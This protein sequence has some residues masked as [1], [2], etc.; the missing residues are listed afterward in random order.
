MDSSIKSD[1]SELTLTER[2]ELLRLAR[3]RGLS[4]AGAGATA[5]QPVP[6]DRRA[7][8]SFS[9]QRLWFLERMGDAGEAYFVRNRVR[10]HGH[11]DQN[12]LLRALDEIVARHESLRTTFVEWG[13]EVEQ[14]IGPP[15]SGCAMVVHDLTA[16]DD[17]ELELDSLLLEESTESFD[18]EEGPLFRGRLIKLAQDDHVLLLTM[19][20]IVSD[21]WS[22]GVL[23]REMEELYSASVEGRPA[24]LAELPIQY[25]DYAVWQGRRVGSGEHREQLEYWG[26]KLSGAPALLELPHGRPRPGEIDHSGDRVRIELDEEL[27]ADLKALS[28]ENGMTL[29]MTLLTGWVMLLGRLSARD[30]IVVG[31]P[32][33]NRS[34]SEVEGLI[35]FFVNLVSLRFDL[36]EGDTVAELLE[37]VREGVV[38]SQRHQDVP[39]EQVVD[40]LQPRRSLAYHPIFQVMF[41]WQGASGRGISLPGISVEGVEAPFARPAKTDIAL[42]LGERE[43]RITGSLTYATALFDAETVERYAGYLVRVFRAMVT[44][45]VGRLDMASVVEAEERE[46]LVKHWGRSAVD[47]IDESP[48]H[49]LFASQASETPDAVAA[50]FGESHAT[51]GELDRRSNRLAARLR[52]FGVGPDTLVALCVE[53]SLD[54]LVGLLGVL[55]AGGAYVP[56]DPRHPKDRIELVLADSEPAVVLTQSEFSVLFAGVRAPTLVFEDLKSP[57][58]GTGSGSTPANGRRRVRPENLTYVMYTSGST[59]RPK[60]VMNHHRAVSSMLRSGQEMWALDERDV[61]LQNIPYSFDASV[62]LFS[63]LIAGSRLVLADVGAESDADNLLSTMLRERV[64]TAQFT[65]SMLQVVVDD[66]RL[67][68]CRSLRRVLAGGERLSAT[69]VERFEQ[70][71]PDSELYHM[72][73]PTEATVAVTGGRCS[74][75]GDRGAVSI[76]RPV[77]NARVYV[78][79]AWGE[80]VPTGVAGELFIGGPQVSRGYKGRGDLTAARFVPDPFEGRPG[81]R[82]YRTGD[83]VRWRPDGELEFM[84]RADQQVKVRGFRI[85]PGEIESALRRME[86]IDDAIVLAHESDP[87]RTGHTQL[88]AYVTGAR[89]PEPGVLR[90][91]LADVLPD[92]MVP[93]AY[94]RLSEFPL[95]TTG[96]VDR[97]ALNAPGSDAFSLGSFEPPRGDR[98]AAVAEIWKEVLGVERVGRNDDF[99]ALGGHSLLAIQVLSRLRRRL[100]I[101]I[102]LRHVFARPVLADFA[103]DVGGAAAV[104]LPVIEPARGDE[105]PPLSFAQRRLWFLEQLGD[106]GDAYHIHGRLRLRGSLDE[107]AL[108]AALDEVVARHEALRTTFVQVGDT[109]VQRIAPSDVGFQLE[110]VDLTGQPDRK[111][112]FAEIVV[113]EGSEHFDL[114]VGPLIRGRL[115]RMEEEEHL[116]FV[117]MHHIV[118]DGWSMGVLT[119]ELSLLYNAFRAGVPSPLGPLPIQYG[120]YAAWQRDWVEGEVL[121]RQAEFWAKSLAGAPELLEL[122]LDR[123]RPDEQNHSGAQHA[124]GLDAALTRELDLVA[125]RHGTTVFVVLLS[126]WATLLSRLSG[127]DEVVVGI[128]VANRNRNE[129]EGLIGFFVNTLAVRVDLTGSPTFSEVVRRTAHLVVEA[130]HNQDIP[131]EQVVEV[132]DPTRTLAHQPIFQTMF[133]WQNEPRGE[134]LSLDGLDVEAVESGRAGAAKVDLALSLSE[135]DGTVRGAVTFATAL[136]EPE[137]VARIGGYLVSLLRSVADEQDDAVL[138]IGLMDDGERNQVVRTFNRTAAPFPRDRCAHQLFE[139]R[140]L[141]RPDAIALVCGRRT[142]SY[143][144]LNRRAN[145]LAHHLRRLGVGPDVRVGIYAEKG[146]DVVVAVLAV[147]KA[148]GAH[149]PMD[150][151]YPTDRLRY[152]LS[153]SAPAVV[154][155]QT[156]LLDRLADADI[157]TLVL[158]SENPEWMDCPSSD[159]ELPL[160]DP[161]HLA[162]VIYTSG[163]TGAPKGVMLTHRGLVNLT[164]ADLPEF[165]VD[166]RSRVLQFSSFSFDAFVFETSMA[167]F[168]GA[169]LV[170]PEESRLLGDDLGTLV[171][172]ERITHSVLPASVLSAMPD[173]T[174]LS[175][176]EALISTGEAPASA[177]VDRWRR[178]RTLVNGYG[179]TESSI[180]ATL[181]AYGDGVPDYTCIGG[182][183]PNTQIYVL[184]RQG[185]PVPMGVV[186]ELCIGGESVARGYLGRPDLTAEQFVADPFASEGGSRLYRTGDLARW[187]PDGTLRFVGRAD[188][189]VKLRGFR[190]EL[191]EIETRLL[192]HAEVREAV[193]LAREDEPG[194]RRLVAYL[195]TKGAPTADDLREHLEESLPQYMVP[196]AYVRLDSLPLSPNGKLDR[197]ALPAPDAAAFAQRRYEAPVGDVER[198]LADIWSGLLS[199]PQV[200]RGDNFFELGGHSLLAVRVITQLRDRGL[201]AEVRSLFTA[202]TLAALAEE[203]GTQSTEISVPPNR[204]P[205]GADV[206]TPEMIPLVSLEREELDRIVASVPGG[207]AN[208]EDIYPLAPLQEG[209]FF[210]HLMTDE[211]DPYLLAMTSTFDDRTQLDR[212]LDAQ[213]A[214]IDRHAIMRTAVIWEGVKEPVQVVWRRAPIQVEE[215]ELDPANGD[216][217]DQLY[218]RFSP[219]RYRIDLR[220]AP[221]MKCVV[222]EDRTS[223]RWVLLFL[224]HHLTGDHTT[225]EVLR[226][227][228]AAHLD[229]GESE[230]A[231][232]LPFRNYVAQARLGTSEEEHSEFFTELLGD[233]RES[234]APYGLLD[235]QGDGSGIEEFR[236]TL[237]EDLST[238]LREHARRLGV[239]AASIFHLAWALVVARASARDEVVFGTVLFGRMHGGEGSDRVVGPFINTLPI[240][241]DV[242]TD[243]VEDSV[244]STHDLVARLLRHEHASLALAQRCSGVEAPAPLFTT[245]LN[246]RHSG[247]TGARAPQP[248]NGGAAGRGRG[249]ERTNYPLTMTVDDRGHGFSLKAKAKAQ[250]EASRVAA[251][252]MQA[253]TGL[254]DALEE[255]PQAPVT[256]ID[257]LPAEERH[258]VLFAW[259]AS[260][261][262]YPRDLCVHQLFEGHAERTPE[263]VALCHGTTCLTYGEL[264]REANRLA[265]HLRRRGIGPDVRVGICMDRSLE[266]VIS[267]LAVLKAGGAYVPLDPNYPPDRLRYMVEDSDP[268]VLLSQA[269]LLDR[270]RDLDVEVVAVDRDTQVWADESQDNPARG[271]LTPGHLTHLVYTSGSTGRPKGVMMEHE[272]GVNRFLWMQRLHQLGVDD[273]GAMLQNSSFSF[274][275]SVWELLWPLSSGARVVL[276]PAEA[277]HDLDGLA[278]AIH[279]GDVRAAFFV[280][281]MLQIFLESGGVARSG[282][283]RIMCGGEALPPEL[284]RRL[285][286]EVP[287]IELFNMFGPSEASQAIVGPVPPVQDGDASVPLGRPVPNTRVYVLDGT[288]EPAPVGVAGELYI[289]GIQMARG[290]RSQPALTAER[291][292]PDPFSGR[293]GARLYRTGDLGRWRPDGTIDFL[294]R[295]D[296]QVKVRGFR[297][298]LGEIEARLLEHADV[299]EAVV[300]AREDVPGERRLVAYFVGGD[301]AAPDGL[302]AHL[303]EVL[304]PYMV[305]AAYVRLDELPLTPNGKLDR[306][307]LA[308]PQGDAYMRRGD[309]AP[310]GEVETAVAEIWSEV[311]RQERIGRWDD[312]FEL[313]GHSLLVVQV[314][315]RVRHAL[316][317]EVPLGEL[318]ARPVLEDFARAVREAGHSE[319]P[320]VTPVPRGDRIPLSLAQQRLWFL[321]QLGGVGSTYH[322]RKRR[323]LQGTLDRPAFVKALDAIVARH[324]ALRTSFAQ[325]D[326]VPEQRIAPRESASFLLIEHD[327]SDCEDAREQLA[328]LAHEEVETPFDLEKGPLVRGR[329]V[330]LAED[331]HVFLMTMHH[332]VG[333]A[334][335]SRVFFEEL[336]ALYAGFCEGTE[337]RLPELDV[338][339]PDYAVWQRAHMDGEGLRRQAEYWTRTLS[340]APELLALPADRPRPPR[341]NHV[342]AILGVELSRELTS[343]LKAL[344]R[345]RG[346][347]LY[348]TV[349]AGWAVVLHRLSGQ[350]EVVVGSPTANRGRKEI[351]GLI[352]FF[353][354]T[355]ALRLDLSETPSVGELLERVKERT[356]E[357]QHH[358]DIPFEQ[359]VELVDPTRSLAYSPLYQVVF[360][361]QNTPRGDDAPLPDVELT[362]VSPGSGTVPAFSDLGLE[363]S[364][365]NG[366]IRGV[367]TYATALFDESTVQRFVGYLERVLEG[368]VEDVNRTVDKLP[369][370][371]ETERLDAVEEWHRAP[372][373]SSDE[374]CIHSLFEEHVDRSPDAIAL[375]FGGEA[376]TYQ[377]V[378]QRANALARRLRELGVGPE[379]RVAVCVERSPEMVVALLGVLKAGGAYVPLDPGYPVERLEYMVNDSVPGVMLAQRALQADLPETDVTIVW[380]DDV[381]VGPA[382]RET[383]DRVVDPDD[384]AYVIYTSGSTGRPKGVQVPHR[385]VC[386]V[387]MMQQADFEVGP[388][389]RV[390]QFASL[391]F[392]AAT[393]EMVMALASGATICLGSREELRPGP[394]L[395]ALIRRE[396][397]TI[398]TLPPSALAALPFEAFPALHTITVAGEALP[399]ELVEKWAGQYRLLNL[400]GPTEGSIWSTMSECASDG[401]KPDIG[402]PIGNVRAYVLDPA[403]EP[404]PVGV[405]GELCVGGLGVARGYLGRPDLTADRFLADP[406][407]TG[408]GARMYRTGDLVRRLPDGSLDFLSRLDH[409]IKL[410][411]YRIELGEIAS[412]LREHDGVA[413]AVVVARQDAQ[414]APLLVGYWRGS[415]DLDADALRSHLTDSLPEYMVPAALVSVDAWPLTPNGKLD[416]KALPEPGDDA[417]GAAAFE[418]PHG[419]IEAALAEIWKE[420][421]GRERIGRQDNFF[422]LGG[423]SLLAVQVIALMRDLD[424]HVEVQA[425]F[426]APTLAALAAAAV[427]DT[428]DVE[429]PANRIPDPEVMPSSE[430]DVYL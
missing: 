406:F 67:A 117:D 56:L 113:R 318:F 147:L 373:S 12:A 212:Y 413:D 26:H 110:V 31:T 343:S 277:H 351:E 216:V 231:E 98:E 14:R 225:L 71:V 391:S 281:S 6:R 187:N 339:Y 118:S 3:E 294:G 150:P 29:F 340:G 310:V 295:R 309:E 248:S 392:D 105:A 428:G 342:G 357:A 262:E 115:L 99:F 341:M 207:A 82:L 170:V 245:L 198:A 360:T 188:F 307:A 193:V 94:V 250:V 282:L 132:L 399:V 165:S 311:L 335:S 7:P 405:A 202:P 358:Q 10:L 213:Q 384:L 43:G 163:S 273:P 427:G 320:P 336:S 363:L 92:Y 116:L 169:V 5:I 9:Q 24:A 171:D 130:Q 122:P 400:Y 337:P 194:D 359:V 234:T 333:D 429:V 131:F 75:N 123:G 66:G 222:T 40:H 141:A 201:H 18:L 61:V 161:G 254:V 263:A 395:A 2:R 121:Q 251:L 38:E 275:A 90:A 93:A 30:D 199:I 285:R 186:G 50:V 178:S 22:S 410:R 296:H 284:V 135:R 45:P 261:A 146:A 264:N 42:E 182:P 268:G 87:A 218:E 321:E 20:H 270:V 347:T 352:G 394:D 243:G 180:T 289:G 306:S 365:Q 236:L 389:D 383:R 64:T 159:V 69:V 100:G 185:Q 183:I 300:L 34:R 370:Q 292:V 246:Y 283:R 35:G 423:H 338:Q 305:P 279:G 228:I 426:E 390:L 401:R 409:Q 97:G 133:A 160:I 1:A 303:T 297:I 81:A 44:D 91:R 345:Q 242:K 78:L 322:L 111:E 65:V 267:L 168:R 256:T 174:E 220:A 239:S 226:S 172:N 59:G 126:A 57:I 80:V 374:L 157:P 128:P 137:T 36:S 8:V 162:C 348:M 350:D 356:L 361:W 329:L 151:D 293:P 33:A 247:G 167:L 257:V 39:F 58:S 430:E 266:M 269:A 237:D 362:T 381:T 107:D 258:E 379:V 25:G 238:R 240:R 344:A 63:P 230:L 140:V 11:L 301:E 323:R 138:D 274:D 152:M 396:S 68:G 32:V 13:D 54:M 393:F 214:V 204:I 208:V 142:L 72:Y 145:R 124:I 70:Q 210:H 346:A 349:L 317:A 114:E 403:L 408:P 265:H 260:E 298:E 46:R 313:G 219:R 154:V 314:V 60:G 420:V 319:L 272:G 397:V 332:I 402:L 249:E 302:R 244:R 417:F 139:E 233:I 411:G 286:E 387:A 235:V 353:V 388:G 192:A 49:E 195:V 155:V 369:L 223:G 104:A 299:R 179:P 315:S 290:Y 209:I 48:V 304:P 376:F 232:P 278:D 203:I 259:N 200:S 119:H 287:G 149:V 255:E 164:S 52:D 86:D 424:L 148:G 181:H 368:M 378:D 197:K 16:E 73:G 276:S 385:G 382:D 418:A 144:G 312:F 79:D 253:V 419:P 371:S 404:V 76:G 108:K 291:F 55:K 95:T 134:G 372:T 227:E 47:C 414:G 28:R 422:E 326:G 308:A 328:A 173:S 280:P 21:G 386:N 158:D 125:R 355:L 175:S 136:F 23:L 380:L 217:A 101:D 252:M 84:G 425:L 4:R 143:D 41:V 102:P 324:E 221:M 120:D 375:T 19:H 156:H 364:E 85:E 103:A 416:R 51:Y 215:I 106:L 206:I 334:W 166:E 77:P 184:D 196:A 229:G 129:V 89:A 325:V 330:R 367:A 271:E 62:R 74:A 205:S 412:R 241:I 109:P 331:D 127:Q 27:T 354:N 17:T 288:G 112:R 96:K 153:E 377:A 190:I 15:D 224:R 327:L 415:D 177:L 211:G 37:Q 407:G 83:V 421:L 316:D 53:R 398:V 366:R 191:S 176:I 189:Q 88:V